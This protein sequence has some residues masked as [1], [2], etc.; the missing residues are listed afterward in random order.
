MGGLMGALRSVPGAGLVGRAVG[1]VRRG[2]RSLRGQ[3]N[4]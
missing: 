3:G 4:S 1:A 2:V